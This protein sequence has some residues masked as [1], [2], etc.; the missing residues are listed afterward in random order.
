MKVEVKKLDKLKRVLTVNVTGDRFNKDKDEFYAA[1]AKSLQVP[2]FRR[3]AAPVDVVV[4]HHGKRLKE[5]FVEEHISRYY[6]RALGETKLAAAGAPRIYDV[7]ISDNGLLFSAEFEIRPRLE[8][9]DSVYKGIKLK[10]KVNPPADKEIDKVIDSLR[11]GLKKSLKDDIDD[12][13]L[14][15]WSGYGNI[16]ALR[17]AIRAELLV[18]KM[19]ARRRNIDASVAKHLL[20][21][22]KIDMPQAEVLRYKEQLMHRELHNLHTQGIS[23]ADLE[24]YKK[25]IEDKVAQR[26]RDEVK[27]FYILAAV[28]EKENIKTDDSANL[29]QVALGFILSQANY[30]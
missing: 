27:L 5:E 12:T 3:G 24:K 14:A 25:D 8:I 19:R 7:E 30:E 4:K 22:V 16:G 28:A 15:R 13:H 17:E 21:S 29:G 11:Q 18:E 10:E 9:K 26:A 23:D 6:S 1:R 20:S 2:G